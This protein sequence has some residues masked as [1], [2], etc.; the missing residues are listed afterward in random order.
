MAFGPAPENAWSTLDR[1][2]AKGSPFPGYKGG[3][4]F[5]NNGS[6]GG[7][8][9]PSS[10][11]GGDSVSYR[12]WDVNP[13]VKGVNRGGERIVTGSVNGQIVS[14]YYTSNH[15]LSFVQFFGEGGG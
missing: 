9:L 2:Q 8:M 4:T 10:T 11:S 12:E 5:A 14:A 15:Y 6:H 3:S 1:V 7:E 13:Y